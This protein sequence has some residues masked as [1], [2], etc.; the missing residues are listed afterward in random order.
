MKIWIYLNG[1]QQ[2]P[3]TIDQLRLLPLTPETPVWY[4]GLPEW[5]PAAQAPAIAAWFSGG[6]VVA[7]AP[8]ETDAT[9]ASGQQSVYTASAAPSAPEPPVVERRPPTYMVWCILLTVLCCSPLALAGIITG[10]ISSSRYNEGRYDAARRLS[11][12]TEWLLIL[13]IVFAI[14]GLPVTLAMSNL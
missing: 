8:S 1:L 2:G 6:D 9:P 14:I 10:A 7:P 4:E 12:A 11:E 3:Y 5:T 13:A